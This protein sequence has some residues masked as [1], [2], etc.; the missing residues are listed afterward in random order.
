MITI[1][2]KSTYLSSLREFFAHSSIHACCLSMI[3]C[4]SIY[5]IDKY[6]YTLQN[7]R[8]TISPCQQLGSALRLSG[9]GAD[10]G[11]VYNRT[12]P[13]PQ[14]PLIPLPPPLEN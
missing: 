14:S 2:V 6:K 9:P 3:N 11:G 1:K 10:Y 12:P 13:E 7:S 8:Y 5:N 4:I